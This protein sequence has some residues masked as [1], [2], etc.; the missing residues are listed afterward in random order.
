VASSLAS[1]DTLI[2]LP[3]SSEVLRLHFP[4]LFPSASISQL[5]YG[6]S[7][8]LSGFPL[9]SGVSQHDQQLRKLP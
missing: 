9:I 7:R 3:S 2:S 1:L 4:R 5:P 8:F 6:S